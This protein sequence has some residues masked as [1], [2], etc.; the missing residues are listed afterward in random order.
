MLPVLFYL[1][2]RRGQCSCGVV[3]AH[4]VNILMLLAG[5][6]GIVS[7]ILEKAGVHV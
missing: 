5:L 2:L 1:K 4:T 7:F 3:L 6:L